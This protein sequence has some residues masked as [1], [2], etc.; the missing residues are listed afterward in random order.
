[1]EEVT[2]SWIWRTEDM[3]KKILI[4]LNFVM[5]HGH[6]QQTLLALCHW[7]KLQVKTVP[8]V[9]RLNNAWIMANSQKAHL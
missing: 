4:P 3:S 1:M 7:W 2:I 6:T 8:K 9:T 5:V